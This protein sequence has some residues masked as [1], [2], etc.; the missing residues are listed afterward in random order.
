MSHLGPYV[1]RDSSTTCVPVTRRSRNFRHYERD[2][3][4]VSAGNFLS[5]HS[6][7]RLLVYPC[8]LWSDTLHTSVASFWEPPRQSSC[9]RPGR[10]STLD[11]RVKRPGANR[12][13]LRHPIRTFLEISRQT[14]TLRTHKTYVPLVET[15][16]WVQVPNH[17]F[18]DFR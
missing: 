3:L 5:V 4:Y 1:G 15:F 7:F 18:T 12:R 13:T 11:P 9:L 6:A 16:V 10:D 14:K 17:S 2:P 8:S